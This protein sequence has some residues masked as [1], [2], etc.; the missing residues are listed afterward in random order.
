MPQRAN[1]TPVLKSAT[2]KLMRQK[3]F[4]QAVSLIVLLL[5]AVGVGVYYLG[6]TSNKSAAPITPSPTSTN[7]TTNWKTY[8]IPSIGEF[9]YPSNWNVFSKNTPSPYSSNKMFS[10][11]CENGYFFQSSGVTTTIVYIE[12]LKPNSDTYCY[13]NGDFRDNYQR[14][15]VLNGNKVNIEVDKWKSLGSAQSKWQGDLFQLYNFSNKVDF[16]LVYKE[17]TDAQAELIFDQILSTFK[18]IP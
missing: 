7:E 11:V 9:Q 4:A 15:T 12:V 17:S 16:V 10:S 13:S 2:L 6:K 3:G 1:L 5:A 8:K 14:Q 18:S